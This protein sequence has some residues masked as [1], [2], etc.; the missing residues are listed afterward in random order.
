MATYVTQG[1]W[2]PDGRIMCHHHQGAVSYELTSAADGT[3]MTGTGDLLVVNSDTSG[4]LHVSTTDGTD[5]AASLKTHRVTANIL[6][7]VAGVLKGTFVSF[8]ADA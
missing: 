6:L 8:L 1:R 3:L 5:K 2:A 4:W 7:P